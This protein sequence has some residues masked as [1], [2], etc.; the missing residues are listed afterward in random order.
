MTAFVE[1]GDYFKELSQYKSDQIA[2]GLSAEEGTMDLMGKLH[3]ASRRM[4]S[5]TCSTFGESLGN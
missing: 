5:N 3:D 2:S 4:G 1:C